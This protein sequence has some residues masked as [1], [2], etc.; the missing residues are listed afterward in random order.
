M[1]FG[2]IN[3]GRYEAGATPESTHIYGWPMNNYWVTNFNADQRGEFEFTYSISSS[4]DNG[5]IYPTRFG[6]GKRIPMPGRVLPPGNSN[7]KDDLKSVLE[8]LPENLVMVSAQPVRNAPGSVILHLREIAGE[9]SGLIINSQVDLQIREVNVIGEEIG[10]N[11]ANIE[12][13]PW[14]VKFIRIN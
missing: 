13:E 6:W 5:H 12:F 9:K 2:G 4:A 11:S 7:N 3:T 14:E 10:S 8:I 1:Q